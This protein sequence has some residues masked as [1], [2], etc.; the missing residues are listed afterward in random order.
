MSMIQVS[1]DTRHCSPTAFSIPGLIGHVLQLDG[2]ENNPDDDKKPPSQPPKRVKR[3]Q[4]AAQGH[5]HRPRC[6]AGIP[7]S[8]NNIP[9]D[10]VPVR[11]TP[12]I[13]PHP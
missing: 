10:R 1:L 12:V 6:E 8:V 5:F 3:E 7:Q 13:V 9:N 2:G 4:R 11:A